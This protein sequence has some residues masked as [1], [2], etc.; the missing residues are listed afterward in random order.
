MK[1]TNFRAYPGTRAVIWLLD[2]NL[3]G[4]S[5]A[6]GNPF[7][8]PQQSDAKRCDHLPNGTFAAFFIPLTVG[9]YFSFAIVSSVSAAYTETGYVLFRGLSGAI[10]ALA[11]GSPMLAVIFGSVVTGCVL[12][13][14]RGSRLAFPAR[15]LIFTTGFVASVCT[16]GTLYIAATFMENHRVPFW[17]AS[18]CLLV[19]CAFA[20]ECI[21]C[22]AKKQQ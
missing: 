4:T 16:C 6:T 5:I 20:S 14:L 22:L 3:K 15:I 17:F 10:L 1:W 8:S 21:V 19:V 11:V 9:S 18:V 12:F 7:Q 13:R 2:E